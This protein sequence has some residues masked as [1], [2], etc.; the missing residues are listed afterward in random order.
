[1]GAVIYQCNCGWTGTGDT[2][3]ESCP[4]CPELNIVNKVNP[5]GI[6][7]NDSRPVAFIEIAADSD[8]YQ[9][10]RCGVIR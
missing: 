6:A 8:A 1:M 3:R 4:K 9:E 5:D 2:Y 7:V 10:S